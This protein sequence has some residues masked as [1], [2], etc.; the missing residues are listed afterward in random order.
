MGRKSRTNP[1]HQKYENPI[2]KDDVQ[3]YEKLITV[4]DKFTLF[5]DQEIEKN[6]TEYVCICI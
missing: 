3:F 5:Y 2:N 6:I 1:S 4:W